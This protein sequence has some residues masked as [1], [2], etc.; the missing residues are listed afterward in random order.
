MLL[1]AAAETTGLKGVVSE[2]AG[3]RSL[4][5]HLHIPT[6]GAVQKGLTPWIAQTG[7]LKVRFAARRGMWR[8]ISTVSAL[9]AR[10]SGFVS[11]RDHEAGS[12][13]DQRVQGTTLAT[14]TTTVGSE[15]VK[16]LLRGS[17][18]VW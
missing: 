6:L 4:R 16:H 3:R 12:A 14:A 13:A 8:A 11:R 7:A 1:Q 9:T 10:H 2:G 15:I 18:G 5:E 17:S